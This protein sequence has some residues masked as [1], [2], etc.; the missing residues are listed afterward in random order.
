M[1]AV[2]LPSFSLASENVDG[3]SAKNIERSIFVV[4]QGVLGAG[5]RSIH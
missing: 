5:T 1:T 4:R 2:F 3:E